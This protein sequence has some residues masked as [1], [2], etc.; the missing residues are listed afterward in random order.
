[1]PLANRLLTEE[2]LEAPEARLALD[3]AFCE[4]CALAQLT[5]S[6]PPEVLFSEYP[7]FS[8]YSD[9][10]V[11]N[12]NALVDRIIERRRLGPSSLVMEV[13]SNDGYLLQHYVR[14]GVPVL[15]IDPASNVARAAE[16]RGVP[17]LPAFFSEE[18]AE[19]FRESG[20]RADVLHANNVL[21][22]VP[23]LDGFVRG[24]TRVLAAGGIAVI[25]TPY[26]G[27]LVERLEFDTIYHEHV[28]YYSLTSL[29]RVFHRSGLR[30]VDVE[31]IP[32]HG[33]SLRVFGSLDRAEPV[34]PSVFRLLNV[35]QR[36]RLG[37][38]DFYRAFAERAE[39]LR[40]DLRGMLI[41]LKSQGNRIAA[42][43]AAAKGAILLNALDLPDGIVDFVVDRSP[44]KQGRYMPGV[45]LPVVPPNQLLDTMPDY[46]LLL[47][48][49]IAD[50][51]MKQQAEYRR[52]GGRF[53]V[54]VP[55][56]AIV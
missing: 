49:N 28:F 23:D 30:I 42:Y 1:M 37:S 15:G 9:T 4:Q 51:V 44:H 14:A 38:I 48:W 39:T 3:L 47:V 13:A 26:V 8:S 32:I 36:R 56:P 22:H 29:D 53:I 18:L 50:E 16:A 12:A 11:Q 41:E 35:E 31:R 21:A 34:R 25:E 43:G 20:R 54:P 27:D 7:Y 52:R 40:N 33:G 2:E 46:V 55:V 5:L 10:V 6:V 17:T 19:E 45:H 24:I